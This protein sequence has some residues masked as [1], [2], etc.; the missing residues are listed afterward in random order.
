MKWGR[1]RSTSTRTPRHQQSQRHENVHV[2]MNK[3]TLSTWNV[4]GLLQRAVSS[5]IITNTNT[6][7]VQKFPFFFFRS[8]IRSISPIQCSL[9]MRRLP[10]TVVV[11]PASP[12]SPAIP[13]PTPEFHQRTGKTHQYL[14]TS[15]LYSL[16]L[17]SSSEY[18]FPL[19]FSSLHRT[20]CSC[21]FLYT[22]SFSIF[23]PHLSLSLNASHF[24]ILSH[25]V[26]V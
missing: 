15:P 14:G 2:R 8:A 1:C 23:P 10:L 21:A 11:L 20:C 24:A 16:F 26:S 3:Q 7:S 13:P 6:S 4:L 18:N 19:F 9:T 17:C 22:I 25:F 12:A 5:T